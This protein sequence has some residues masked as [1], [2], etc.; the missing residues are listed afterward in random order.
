MGLLICH[1]NGICAT[2]PV[3]W[4][5][6]RAALV[7]PPSSV[8]DEATAVDGAYETDDD[9]ADEELGTATSP[10][11]PPASPPPPRAPP[12]PPPLDAEWV[13]V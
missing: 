1:A 5:A 8:C 10:P 13:I 6:V 7:A 12:T 9:K 4:P 11:S 3:Y 2:A